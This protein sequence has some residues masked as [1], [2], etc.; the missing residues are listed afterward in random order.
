MRR[1]RVR[2]S[3]VLASSPTS[4]AE[5]GK[6]PRRSRLVPEGAAGAR[7]TSALARRDAFCAVLGLGPGGSKPVVEP[8]REG[9]WGGAREGGNGEELS[10]LGT[11][12]A[13]EFGTVFAAAGGEVVEFSVEESNQTE[14][15]NSVAFLLLLSFSFCLPFLPNLTNC[16]KAWIFARGRASLPRSTREEEDS[17]VLWRLT[18]GRS[19]VER[20][21]RVDDGFVL[22]MIMH[23]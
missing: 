19:L 3:G 2:G 21:R 8:V 12:R 18:L 5:L 20:L 17:G 9:R 1:A 11:V 7:G 4:V 6:E 23:Q 15:G 13:A 14:G 16:S 22:D 10:R